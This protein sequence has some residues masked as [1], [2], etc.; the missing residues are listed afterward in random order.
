MKNKIIPFL[1]K[2][3]ILAIENVEGIGFAIPA[4]LI[5]EY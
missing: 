5:L 4:D 2:A 1:R 3:G